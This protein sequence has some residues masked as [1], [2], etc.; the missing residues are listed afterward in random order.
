[1]PP[2]LG[3]KNLKN[4]WAELSP[5]VQAVFRQMARALN[6]ELEDE[7]DQDGSEKRNPR[8]TDD[9]SPRS[10]I[11]LLSYLK[12]AFDPLTCRQKKE[13]SSAPWASKLP[14]KVWTLLMKDLG[15]LDAEGKPAHCPEY[16]DENDGEQWAIEQS[17]QPQHLPQLAARHLRRPQA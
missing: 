3:E 10:W 17:L 4:R 7:C 12:A 14:E 6:E 15:V 1:M 13:A 8:Q 9:G 11:S 5:P 2:S 16:D